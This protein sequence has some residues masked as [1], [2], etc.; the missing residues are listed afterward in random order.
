MVYKRA[1]LRSGDIEAFKLQSSGLI[2]LDVVLLLGWLRG[3]EVECQS[4]AGELTLSC[5]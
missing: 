2:L 5:A 1:I 3:T 4:L